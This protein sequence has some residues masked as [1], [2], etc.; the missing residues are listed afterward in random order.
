MPTSFTLPPYREKVEAM[1]ERV[2]ARS[3]NLFDDSLHQHIDSKSDLDSKVRDFKFTES[4]GERNLIGVLNR[5]E[6]EEKKEGNIIDYNLTGDDM[7]YDLIVRTSGF[8]GAEMVAVVQE[9]GML[10][11]DEGE[12]I[13]DVQHL[14]KAIS[15][16][17]PQITASMLMFYE[18]IAKGY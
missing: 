8:S 3:T 13:L 14:Y 10:A 9:A 7:L 15:S 17:K 6:K 16:I 4:V 18:K 12:D 5:K 2:Q 11:I 1:E